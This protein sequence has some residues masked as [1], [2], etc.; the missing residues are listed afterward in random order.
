[1]WSAWCYYDI[2]SDDCD[3]CLQG[4]T[5]TT[6]EKD[7]GAEFPANEHYFGL[8]NVSAWR[9]CW[10]HTGPWASIHQEDAVLSV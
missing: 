3:F 6:L 9:G 1:M 5:A 2:V 10:K 7:I 4:A 8:V